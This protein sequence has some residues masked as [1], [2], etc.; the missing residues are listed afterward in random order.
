M[1]Y[2]TYLR[3]SREDIQAE[4]SGMGDT[5]ARHRRTLRE[6]AER[7][8][9]QVGA[10]YEEVVSGDS[11]AARPQM[12]RLL[13]EVQEGCWEGVLVM[14]I[15]RLARGDTMDQG[16]VANAFKYS[17]T[18]IITPSKTYDPNSDIDEEYFE[19]SLF[20]SRREYK[21]INRRL[22]AGSA[23]SRREGKFTSS[24]P[25]FGYDRQKL[26]GEKG[27]I[28]APNADA[29]TVRMIFRMYLHESRSMTEISKHLNA[30]G[31]KTARGANWGESSVSTILRNPH[32][33]GYTANGFRPAVKKI[34]NGEVHRSRPR[35]RDL[36][37][38]DGRHEALVSREDFE[39]VKRKL[40]LNRRPPVPKIYGAENPL[41]GLLYCDQCGKRLQRRPFNH[42]SG[43][44]MI[45][46]TRGC[47]TVMHDMAEVE[48]M[49][50]DH[51]K[52]WL[53]DLEADS[54]AS[55]HIAPNL[56]DLRAH[57]DRVGSDLQKLAARESRTYLFLEDGTYT[58]E[59]FKSRRTAILSER[60]ALTQEQQAVRE[61]L[62]AAERALES[63]ERLAPA[64]RHVL[65]VYWDTERKDERNRLLKTIIRRI[66][67][68]KTIKITRA[69]RDT[70]LDL[71]LHP[72][73]DN[74]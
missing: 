24:I 29:D 70:D 2:A 12:Q 68:H 28:L 20:M 42:G 58:P 62:A 46:P 71:T 49:V 56:A 3:K 57:L 69:S 10:I 5:L 6:L 30:L 45:C 44:A 19:F 14:E 53:R 31:I 59:E 11:I 15:E 32:Y 27:W 23:A 34:V 36:Q 43:A 54:N 67:Y 33:A 64:I 63:H 50:I 26:R 61:E 47:P 65:D 13:Q 7:Q 72:L 41:M 37:L 48:E 16:L 39:A 74:L 52:K 1:A 9:L 60:E 25:P 21:T 38:Y 18:K 51:L 4:R 8:Q 17:G 40:A 66:D 55:A 73:Y 22:K 35:N